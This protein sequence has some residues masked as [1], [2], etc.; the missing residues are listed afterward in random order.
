MELCIDLGGTEVKLAVTD[1]DRVLGSTTLPLDGMPDVLAGAAAGAHR[2]LHEL[3]ASPDAVGIAVPGVVDPRTGLMLHANAK[4]D[5]LR[6]FDLRSWSAAEFG[7]PAGV[8]NDARA[9]LIG[10]VAAG[11]AAG[12]RDAVL[13]TLGTG[14]GTA[15]MIDGVAL[16]GRSGHAGILGGHVT[17]DLDGPACPCG[18]RGCGEAL[19][20]SWALRHDA[21]SSSDT[22]PRPDLRDV[23]A[24]DEHR[25]IRDRFLQ[26]WGTVA[27]SLVHAY[28]P[29]VVVLS[30]GVLRAGAA[31]H[32]P[33][34]AFVRDHLWSSVTMPR[35]IVPELPELSVARGLAVVARTTHPEQED[36]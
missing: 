24:R 32:A 8:E 3:G 9:A 35:F 28:D 13:M 26:V 20:S 7:M 15:A 6:G 25:A 18:N 1:A 14:I 22:A 30:G 27:T 17:V 21:T 36:L 31:V 10:E 23:F 2:L 29:S 5:A 19:A 33:I 16:R 34:E 4:Y 12:E 11:S